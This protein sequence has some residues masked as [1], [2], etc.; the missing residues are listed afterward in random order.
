[1]W[2][3]TSENPSRG[4]S[5]SNSGGFQNTVRILGSYD[6]GKYNWLGSNPHFVMEWSRMISVDPRGMHIDEMASHEQLVI[7]A[8][9]PDIVFAREATLES[10]VDDS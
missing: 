1:M 4:G 3:M 7:T 10:C 8:N 6:D 2:S 5:R 9:D